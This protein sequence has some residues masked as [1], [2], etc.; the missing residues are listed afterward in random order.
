MEEGVALTEVAKKI[1]ALPKANMKRPRN[2]IITYGAKPTI[3]ATN[4]HSGEVTVQEVPITPIPAENVIDTN[5]AG[6]AFV[7]GFLSQLYQD[8]DIVTCVKAGNYL[9]GQVVQ[10]GG[11]TFPDDFNF[12]I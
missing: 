1:A 3:I 10:R 7:G 12:E 4:D 5:G 9:G 2:V 11:C 8:K 6:D